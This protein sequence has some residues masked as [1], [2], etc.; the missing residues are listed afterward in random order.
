MSINGK[1]LFK[2]TP[3]QH[4][5]LQFSTNFRDT[6]NAKP[7]EK[8]YYTVNGNAIPPHT[9]TFNEIYDR[10]HDQDGNLYIN[11]YKDDASK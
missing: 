7:G 2:D 11:Y 1:I 8:Y 6:I 5:M 4:T 3:G 10:H 9:A